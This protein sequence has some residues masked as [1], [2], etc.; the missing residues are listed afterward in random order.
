L[1][2]ESQSLLRQRTILSGT[3]I[4]SLAFTP[5]GEMLVTGGLD[6]SLQWWDPIT[7]HYL[8]ELQG[9]LLGITGLSFTAFGSQLI[10]I[11]DDAAV[12]V[13]DTITVTAGD[14]DAARLMYTLRDATSRLTSLAVNTTGQRLVA[15]GFQRIWVWDLIT[16]EL[17]LTHDG[18]SDWVN[19]M[20]F[21]PDGQ[22][23]VTT[24]AAHRLS[25]WDGDTLQPTRV[26]ILEQASKPLSLAFSPD[27]RTLAS[28][29][30]DGC[31]L[32]WDVGTFT[33]RQVLPAYSGGITSLAFDPSGNR[34]ASGSQ[35]GVL[36]VWQ[37]AVPFE[38]PQEQE[39]EQ[40]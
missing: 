33:L 12:R 22:V 1:I 15:G 35:A 19:A 30:A 31:I 4:T 2:L 3:H 34:L 26:V 6:A 9:H 32:L 29:Q 24:D 18:F 10:S 20:V 8:G 23:L 14:I 27:G 21:R 16:G 11:S 7:G 17:L 5:D 25:F 37:L 13:W 39:S 28:G 38:E 40:F 36:R